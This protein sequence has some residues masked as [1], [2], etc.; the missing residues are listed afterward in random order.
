[1]SLTKTPSSETLLFNFAEAV[2]EG[3]VERGKTTETESTCAISDKID[4]PSVDQSLPVS[5]SLARLSTS[6]PEPCSM[7]LVAHEC[8]L[9]RSAS[10]VSSSSKDAGTQPQE[11]TASNSEQWTSVKRQM[12]FLENLHKDSQI[13]NKKM[14]DSFEN[15]GKVQNLKKEFEAKS[16]TTCLDQMSVSAEQSDNT[17]KVA[18]S[19]VSSLPS[20][21]VCVHQT[22]EPPPKVVSD[23]LNFKSLRSVF[24][25]KEDTQVKLRQ[26]NS[27][28][29]RNNSRYSCFEVSVDKNP[30][31]LP[32]PLISNLNKTEKGDS[33]YKRPPMVPAVKQI[34]ATVIATA[35]KKQ[36]Q[37]GK[38]HPLSRL[39]IKPR[40][41][42]PVYNTM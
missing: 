16:S 21:P 10:N 6:A 1:M 39:N 35:A 13:S 30:R 7:E 12:S 15:V 41:N 27:K 32:T 14:E 36:Q 34:A 24:E 33:E 29:N 4:I 11:G 18:K 3:L 22:K 19:R 28:P 40:H 17:L 38:T 8:S 2:N 23:D 37:Y 9:S 26:K 42:N 5:P 20:S 25:N 31:I